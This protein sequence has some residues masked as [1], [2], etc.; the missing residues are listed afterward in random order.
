M[1]DVAPLRPEDHARWAEL[2]RQYLDFYGTTMPQ[3]VYD[4]TWSRLLAGQELHGLAAR[5]GDEIV[6]ITHFL[7][8]PTAWA[9]TPACYLQDLFVHAAA[10]NKGAARALIAAVADRARQARAS[11]LYWLTQA[12]NATGRALYDKVA[13]HTGFIRYEHAL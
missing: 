10:R 7:F 8:H 1:I 6:G 4:H 11:R 2:W 9:L 3:A 12:D 13:R 5:D